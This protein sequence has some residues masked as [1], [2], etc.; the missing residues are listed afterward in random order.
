MKKKA[1]KVVIFFTITLIFLFGNLIVSFSQ[2]KLISNNIDKENQEEMNKEFEESIAGASFYGIH[3]MTEVV[4]E[5]EKNIL[6]EKKYFKES[7]FWGIPTIQLERGM[8]K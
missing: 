7:R 8:V 4:E 2:S 3:I 6:E 5:K 1:W